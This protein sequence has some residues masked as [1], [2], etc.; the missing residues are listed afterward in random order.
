MGMVIDS[1]LKLYKRI[2]LLAVATMMTLTSAN[3]QVNADQVMQIGRNVLSMEEYILSIHYFNLAIKAKPYMAEPYYYRGLAKLL[4]DDF[5]G[6]EEDCTKAIELNKFLTEAYRVRGYARQRLDKDSLA[7]DDFKKGLE[8]IPVDKYFLYYKAASQSALHQYEQADSTFTLLRRYYP[9]FDAAYSERAR[10]SVA[11]GDTAAALLYIDTALNLNKKEPFPFMLRAEIEVKKKQWRDAKADL[12][13]AID[14]LPKETNLYLNRA[15]VKYCDDDY[16]GAMSDYNYILELEPD[17][18]P[19]RYNRGL[20]RYE[21]KDLNAAAD[22]FS[23]VLEKDADNFHARYSRALIALEVGQYKNAIADLRLIAQKYPKFYPVYYAMAQCW[24]NLGDTKKTIENYNKAEALVRNYVAN[25]GKNPLDKPTINPGASNNL[26]TSDSREEET[27]MQVM[28]KFNQLVTVSAEVSASASSGYQETSTKGK[29]QDRDMK[30]EPEPMYAL[31]LYDNTN[32][33]R[34]S[35]NYFRGLADANQSADAPFHLYIT[36]APA[37]PSE[38]AEID[39]LFDYSNSSASSEQDNNDGRPLDYLS[40]GIVLFLLRD[41]DGA[42]KAFDKSLELKD[43]FTP[44]LMARGY[45]LYSMSTVPDVQI[46]DQSMKLRMAMQDFDKALD[47]DPMLIYAWFNRGALYYQAGE[48]TSALEC[49]NK[50][51]EINPDF[52]EAYYN[53]ALTYMRLGNKVSGKADLSKA[54]E[55]GVLPSYNLLKRMQ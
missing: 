40:R 27:D 50:A 38:R 51:L 33:L 8:Y 2:V 36:A 5:N 37:T 30:V 44:A 10:M 19:A 11:R 14:L 45:L 9:S 52:G 42:L 43:D 4:L 26:E 31:T 54:G 18:M 53:R 49:Y 20:L 46:N 32:E 13:F 17:N 6:A 15:Y 34:N 24:Q 35:A 3:A 55:L 39:R 29:L 47:I 41:Y 16:F 21:V 23:K 7:L 1:L 12:D 22:D 25:P 48:Y 28:E